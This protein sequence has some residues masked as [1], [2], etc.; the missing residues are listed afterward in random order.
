MWYQSY[1]LQHWAQTGQVNSF[2]S[3][4]LRHHYYAANNMF[5]NTFCKVTVQFGKVGFGSAM[6][7]SN[8]NDAHDPYELRADAMGENI[9]VG[10][11]ET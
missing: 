6:R 2:Q 3:Y 5:I 4:W 11:V 9:Q 7:I 1:W 10:N 8:M